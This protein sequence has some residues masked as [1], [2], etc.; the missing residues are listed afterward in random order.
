MVKQILYSIK[1][2]LFTLFTY[3]LLSKLLDLCIIIIIKQIFIDGNSELHIQ[4]FNV[5]Y[6]FGLRGMIL[7]ID[8]NK[9]LPINSMKIC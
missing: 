6:I 7:E 2:T 5:M 1:N 3:E 9:L 8:Y 4:T